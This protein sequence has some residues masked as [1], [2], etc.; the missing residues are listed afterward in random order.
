MPLEPRITTVMNLADVGPDAPTEGQVMAWDDTDKLFKPATG[1]VATTS[2]K[3]EL[4]ALHSQ[5]AVAADFAKLHAVTATAD[6]LDKA[7]DL[8]AL[9]ADG[10]LNLKVARF[11]FDAGVADNQGTGNH[12]T[13]LSLP[14]NA[15][16]VGGFIDVNTPFTSANANNGTI[17]IGVESQ[18]DILAA[19]PVSGAPYSSI[20]RKA[21]IPHVNT[22]ESTAVKT[23]AAQAVTVVVAVSAL[24]AGKLTGFLYYVVSVVS[25]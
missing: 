2:T 4:D 25:A 14:A 6:E 15:I 22:P 10:I 9:A 23:T 18:V 16:V 12:L 1:T 24:T 11:T 3:A 19:A 13:G 8:D 21:I 7:A 20:G 5:G 17:S